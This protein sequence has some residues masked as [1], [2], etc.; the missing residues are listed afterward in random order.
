MSL[1]GL[2]GV[3]HHFSFAR[4]GASWQVGRWDV[5]TWRAMAWRHLRASVNSSNARH[6]FSTTTFLPSRCSMISLL[7]LKVYCIASPFVIF[8]CYFS[9]LSSLSKW[10]QTAFWL[11]CSAC[12][13][14]DTSKDAV[15][16]SFFSDPV[17]Q[18]QGYPWGQILRWKC[19]FRFDSIVWRNSR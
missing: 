5:D 17:L 15:F 8:F 7:R 2:R 1:P 12:I 13:Q 6:S 4:Q 14:A 3:L 16:L 11:Q 18:R 9:W 10:V 19:K